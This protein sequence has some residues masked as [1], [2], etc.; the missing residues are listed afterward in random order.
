MFTETGVELWQFFF[1]FAPTLFPS[2]EAPDSTNEDDNL[3][4]RGEEKLNKQLSC[5]GEGKSKDEDKKT[6][7]DEP[8]E[9]VSTKYRLRGI[10]VHSGQASGGHYYSFIQMRYTC[11]GTSVGIF[12]YLISLFIHRPPGSNMIKWFKF[13][14]GE[15]TEAKI[16]DEEVHYCYIIYIHVLFTCKDIYVSSVYWDVHV[17]GV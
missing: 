2:G 16:D 17:Y 10:V 1:F 9:G 13:D 4:N 5:E 6:P 8:G 11:T 12:V 7:G 3:D 15:V 14:D